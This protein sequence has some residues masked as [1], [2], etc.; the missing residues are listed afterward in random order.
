MVGKASPPHFE[1]IRERGGRLHQ[2]II[3]NNHDMPIDHLKA[4]KSLLTRNKVKDNLFYLKNS[5]KMNDESV[6]GSQKKGA[7]SSHREKKKQSNAG[8][9]QDDKLSQAY[10]SKLEK[11]YTS[12]QP[13]SYNNI[14]EKA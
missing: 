4:A 14:K 9:Q 8:N 11:R 6:N 7:L 13:V 5:G 10:A 12:R 2:L 1:N 3:K